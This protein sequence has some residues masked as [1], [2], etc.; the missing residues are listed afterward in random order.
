MK[1]IQCKS[2]V[3]L[4][5]SV[6][7][8]SLM[9]FS[10][11]CA[12]KEEKEIKIGAILPLTGDA[13]LAGINSREGMELAV[14]EINQAGLDG[15][16]I[17]VIYEDTQADPK[18]AVSAVNK[19][20]QI[21][22]VQYIIDDS[23]SSVTLAVAPIVEKSKVVLLSTGSTAP[24]ISQAG[25]FIFR[26][27]NSDTLEGE[28]VAKYAVD[29]LKLKNIGVLFANNDY[30]LGLSEVFQS[31]LSKGGLHPSTVEAFEQ[32]SQ[33]YRTQLAKLL[34]KKPE[35]IYLVGYSKDCVKIIQQAKE[36]RYKG[37]WL[38]TTVMLDST[39]TDVI[40]KNSYA[41]YYPVPFIPDTLS[42]KS[43][44][45]SFFSKYKKEP[46][47]LADV[48]YDA[49]MLFR[50]AVEIGGG[51]NGGNIKKGLMNIKHHEGA[52][53]LIEFD[54]NGDVHKPIEIKL[55]K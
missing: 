51:R 9:V 23:I 37:I 54:T 30:G 29:N 50:K 19:L 10:F 31:Q 38:G 34:S 53:G 18:T 36:M 26:I 6:V 48:G 12:K 28:E 15:K 4:I 7:A 39:V 25:E 3:L 33:D 43:F 47:A 44:R 20:I 17:R 5:I 22:N 21:D 55:L 32:G 41:L 1:S 42:A 24:K 52:S 8:A 14:S 13:A 2:A 40:K 27:W 49:V 16:K 46:P 45:D 11:G 35:A